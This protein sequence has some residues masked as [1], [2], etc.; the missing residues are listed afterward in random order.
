MKTIISAI[1][2]LAPWSAAAGEQRTSA[3]V[4]VYD[5]TLRAMPSLIAPATQRAYFTQQLD[6][7]DS[8][9]GWRFVATGTNEIRFRFF[10]DKG[11]MRATDVAP[12]TGWVLASSLSLDRLAQSSMTDLQPPQALYCGS[13]IGSHDNIRTDEKSGQQGGAGYASPAARP[14]Q[15]PRAVP[16]IRV[17]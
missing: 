16:R 11:W 3:W 14:L 15:E 1:A 4:R 13:W 5:V 8:T 10:C 2:L 12:Y 9:N 6:V 17:P 7:L